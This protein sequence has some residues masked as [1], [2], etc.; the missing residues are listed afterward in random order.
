MVY[1]V[2]GFPVMVGGVETVDLEYARGWIA[3]RTWDIGGSG[4]AIDC[5]GNSPFIPIVLYGWMWTT[6]RLAVMVSK[7]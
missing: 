5:A 7:S 1:L 2:D 4:C 3:P 6:D